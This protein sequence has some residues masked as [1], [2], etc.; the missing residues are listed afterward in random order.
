VRFTGQA[1]LTADGAIIAVNAW[2]NWHGSVELSPPA[3]SGA[4]PVLV[5]DI[6]NFTVPEGGLYRFL[7]FASATGD[8]QNTQIEISIVVDAAPQGLVRFAF[9]VANGIQAFAGNPF[10]FLAAG[11]HTVEMFAAQPLSPGVASVLFTSLQ[12]ERVQ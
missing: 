12:L 2:R 9:S 11:Q 4:T 5:G 6:T 3:L 1:D 10:A 8:S 7:N